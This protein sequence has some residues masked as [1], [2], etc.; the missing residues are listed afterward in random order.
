MANARRQAEIVATALDLLDEGGADAVS[1]RAVAERMGVRVHTVSW[2]VSTKARL[3]ELMADAILGRVSFDGLPAEP[4]ERFCEL[5]R[6]YRRA[7]LSHRDGARLVAGRYAAEEH[8]L[9]LVEALVAA[10]LECGLDERTAAWIVWTAVYFTLGI[11]QEEQFEPD[12]VADALRDAVR[13]DAH[14][15]LTHVLG[16]LAGMSFDERFELG[17]ELIARPI[18]ERV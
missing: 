6:R 18:R 7:L 16:H 13:P 9:R 8:T 4:G 12:T 11:T 5:I 3:L 1:L 14:P 17:L 2:H 15:A 10:L